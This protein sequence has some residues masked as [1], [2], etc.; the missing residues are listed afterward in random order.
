M[1]KRV[2]VTWIGHTDL[3]AMAAALP[4]RDRRDVLAAIG[5]SDVA[6]GVGPIKTLVDQHAF[7][8]IHL[9]SDCEPKISRRFVQWLGKPVAV[10]HVKLSNP[11]EHKEVYEVVRSTLESIPGIAEAD[12]SFHLSPGTPAMAA[13]WILLGKSLYPATLYQTYEGRAWITDIPFD[14]T[15]DVVPHLLKNPDRFWQHLSGKAPQ[16]VTGF[17]SIVGTSRAIRLAVGRA[18][19]AAIRDV[20]VLILGQS[21]SGKEMFARAIHAASHR[22]DKPFLAVNCAALSREL[23]ESELFGHVTG[24]FTGADKDHP[25]A[26]EQAHGGTLFLDEVGEC[27]RTLQAKLLRVLQPPPG[28]GPCHRVFRKVGGRQDS[29]SDVR[30]IAATNRDLRE[31]IEAGT[32]RKDLFYRLATVTLKLPTLAER[33]EDIPLLAR[34]LL[35]QINTQFRNQEHGYR[36]KSISPATNAFFQTYPWPGNVRELFNALVQ[37]AVMADSDAL[38][39]EDIAAAIADVPQTETTDVLRTPLGEGFSLER[40]LEDIQR[41]FLRRAMEE[42]RGNKTKAAK[43]LG[44]RYYQT[45]DAQLTR[46]GVTGDW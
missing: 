10:H 2:L 28:Q 16:D 42:A 32:F 30:I 9:L 20:P 26:F 40:H 11:S 17:E 12:L 45:L 3:R 27:D 25:G 1:A 35:A 31:T 8:E 41:H 4:A 24:A 23:L 22:K 29:E 15:V 43:L 36:D 46:L 21:G 13:I 38:E 37:A 18:Q 14:L 19:R 44:M 6:Q 5:A 33:K 39:P 34:A 7:D